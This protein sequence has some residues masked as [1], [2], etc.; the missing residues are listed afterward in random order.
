MTESLASQGVWFPLWVEALARLRLPQLRQRAYRQALVAY[1]RFC[2]VSRQRATVASARQFMTEVEAQ[3]LLGASQRATWKEALNWFFT[4]AAGGSQ[5]GGTVNPAAS[6]PHSPAQG[7][8]QRHTHAK[9]GPR[10]P[11]PAGRVRELAEVR[12][13]GGTRCR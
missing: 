1:L 7:R 10:G 2:K 4:A 8:R 13:A 6:L 5:S 3:R 9:A 11:Q 12:T